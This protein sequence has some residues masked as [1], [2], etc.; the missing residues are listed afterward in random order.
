MQPFLQAF[1]W[2]PVQARIDYS[3]STICHNFFSDSSPANLS[4]LLIVC[5]PSR[6]LRSSADART[7][8]I[9]HVKT[10]T[11]GQRSFSYSAPKQWNSPPSDIRHIQSSHAFKTALESHLYKRHYNNYF[12]FYLLCF[13]TSLIFFSRPLCIPLSALPHICV[14]VCVCVCVLVCVCVCVCGVRRMLCFYIIFSG[15]CVYLKV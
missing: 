15:V 2:L 7:L 11:F 12:K 14:C 10:K 8:H 6:Q 1:H 3:L 5:T 4:D 9:P 13:L